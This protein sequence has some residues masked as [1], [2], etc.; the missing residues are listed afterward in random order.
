L[1]II[2]LKERER[3]R[4]REREP[5]KKNVSQIQVSWLIRFWQKLLKHS[6]KHLGIV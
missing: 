3:E 5:V 2:K 1:K 4:E 6:L